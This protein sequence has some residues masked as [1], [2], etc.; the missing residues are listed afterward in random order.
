MYNLSNSQGNLKMT[1]TIFLS[2]SFILIYKSVIIQYI[3]ISFNRDSILR[4]RNDTLLISPF[5]G[6][7]VY[8]DC[9]TERY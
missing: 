3:E 8:L 1:T 9:L 7:I 6:L 4:Y 5:T 2:S